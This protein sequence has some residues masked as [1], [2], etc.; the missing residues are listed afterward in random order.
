MSKLGSKNSATFVAD[1]TSGFVDPA[2]TGVVIVTFSNGDTTPDVAGSNAFLATNSA[3]TSITNFDNGVEGQFI[4]VQATNGN[5]TIVHDVTK[6]KMVGGANA[7]IAANTALAFTRDASG[8]WWQVGGS[9]GAAFATP[10]IV[11]GSA[12]AAGAASTVIRS[13]STIKAFDDGA[14]PSA[15]NPGDATDTGNDAFAARRDHIHARESTLNSQFAFFD[16]FMYDP[17]SDPAPGASGVWRSSAGG[18]SS[19]WLHDTGNADTTAF[20]VHKFVSDTTSGNYVEISMFQLSSSGLVITL[21]PGMEIGFRVRRDASDFTKCAFRVEFSDDTTPNDGSITKG[22]LFTIWNS[23]LNLFGDGAIG[24]DQI[25]FNGF[26]SANSINHNNVLAGVTSGITAFKNIKMIVTGES[27]VECFV[28]GVSKGTLSGSG[29]SGVY[30]PASTTKLNVHIMQTT[31]YI[32]SAPGAT[33]KSYID[34]FYIDTSRVNRGS[35]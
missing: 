16:D 9:A 32:G 1:L 2:Q 29:S 34:R 5:T 15:S 10:A 23:D 19:S 6:I 20:G 11:L 22:L 25:V 18:G 28:E 24:T 33:Q 27:A 7:V 17:Q 31:A 30:V 12:A 4:R 3:P 14:N 21:V 26:N 8:I 35:N 13:D